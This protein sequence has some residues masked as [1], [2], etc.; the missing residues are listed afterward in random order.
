M[1]R[2]QLICQNCSQE[3]SGPRKGFS[4][5]F[6]GVEPWVDTALHLVPTFCVGC[7]LC[8][9]VRLPYLDDDRVV[10][11]AEALKFGNHTNLIRNIVATQMKCL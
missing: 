7:C 9:G 2:L 11:A 1:S 4:A 5:I 8:Q 6:F 3:P 10:N